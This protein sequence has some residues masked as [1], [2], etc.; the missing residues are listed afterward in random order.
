[1]ELGKKFNNI[2]YKKMVN[3][4]R[5]YKNGL[6][7]LILKKLISATINNCQLVNCSGEQCSPENQN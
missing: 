7:K 1:M 5:C 3:N 4:V 2:K 6:K